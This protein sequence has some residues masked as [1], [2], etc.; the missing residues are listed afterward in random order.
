[1][2]A[3]AVIPGVLLLAGSAIAN[4]VH[5]ARDVTT[6]AI[7]AVTE[8]GTTYFTTVTSIIK[9]TST[10]IDTSTACYCSIPVTTATAEIQTLTVHGPTPTTMTVT[11]LPASPD[12]A[13]AITICPC[14]PAPTNDADVIVAPTTQ[15][16]TAAASEETA[17]GGD[18]LL[19]NAN[20]AIMGVLS[21]QMAAVATFFG[22]IGAGAV[23]L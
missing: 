6:E 3:R 14:Q 9:P 23:F 20:G 5:E 13:A 18:N 2:I 7:I 17:G 11:V 15:S 22:L 10:P 1:M 8:G 16:V 19:L 12:A 21:V 4:Q